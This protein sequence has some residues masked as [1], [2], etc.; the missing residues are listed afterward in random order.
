MARRPD[1]ME[2]PALRPAFPVPTKRAKIAAA[3]LAAVLVASP[4]A[5]AHGDAAPASSEKPPA[6]EARPMQVDP[7]LLDAYVGDYLLGAHAV[8]SVRREADHLSV[9][10]TGQPAVSIYPLSSTRFA[11][12]LVNAEFDFQTDAAGKVTGLTLHQNGVDLAL[13][14]VDAAEAERVAARTTARV[15]SQVAAPG[16]EEAVRRLDASIAAGEPAYELMS[17]ALA[18]ATR[19]QLPKLEAFLT[20]LGPVQEV[21]FLGVNPQGADIY[22]IRH[23]NGIARWSI[24]LGPDGRVEG[25]FVT[26]GP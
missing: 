1:A 18:S 10:L 25:A 3:G 15:K 13:P 9:Q 16:T 11:A 8:L 14:R 17:P 24:V 12:R 20:G 19:E 5:A 26:P 4:A 21:R 22:N 23:A 7:K 2:S 6:A